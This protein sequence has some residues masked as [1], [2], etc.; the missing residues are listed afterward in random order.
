MS[1]VWVHFR[2]DFQQRL[3]ASEFEEIEHMFFR[4]T[5]E[6]ELKDKVGSENPTLSVNDFRFVENFSGN[7]QQQ[8]GGC[9][10]DDDGTSPEQVEAEEEQERS[11][12]RL[13]SV[14]LQRDTDKWDNYLEKSKD[15]ENKHKADQRKQAEMLKEKMKSFLEEAQTEEDKKVTSEER[16]Q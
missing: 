10:V 16:A 1:C 15:F 13:L 8:R 5:L 4:G 7:V 6:R 14:K 12:L 2:P 11:A 9:Q 3:S